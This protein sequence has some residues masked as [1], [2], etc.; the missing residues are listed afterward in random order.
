MDYLSPEIDRLVG[1]RIH[2]LRR[3]AGLPLTQLCK[4]TGL[5]RRDVADIEAGALRP[6]ASELFT[7]ADALGCG[8]ADFWH[9]S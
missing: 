9:G 1:T 6:K 4:R 8:P 3:D 5:L 7:L 2:A